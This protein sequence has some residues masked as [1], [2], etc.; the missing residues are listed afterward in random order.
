MDENSVLNATP[1][2][3]SLD[4]TD[5][6]TCIRVIHADIH[7]DRNS[8]IPKKKPHGRLV[9]VTVSLANLAFGIHNY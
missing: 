8:C 7:D 3:L 4:P 1:V 5:L 9:T 6:L 2:S